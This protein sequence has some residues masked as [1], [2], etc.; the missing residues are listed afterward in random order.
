MQRKRNDIAY[1]LK[2]EKRIS[3]WKSRV[4]WSSTSWIWSKASWIRRTLQC[5]VWKSNTVTSLWPTGRRTSR[6][7]IWGRMRRYIIVWDGLWGRNI[8]WWV[9]YSGKCKPSS[10]EDIKPS[11][12][13][14]LKEVICYEQGRW[15]SRFVWPC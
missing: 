15:N 14:K 4:S 12:Y 5:R 8:W 3:G 2:K 9:W 1:Y 11:R 6:C 10:W 7:W 13:A